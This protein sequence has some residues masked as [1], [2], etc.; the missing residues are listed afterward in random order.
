MIRHHATDIAD[1]GPTLAEFGYGDIII[2]VITPANGCLGAYGVALS[3]ANAPRP[4]GTDT[5]EHNG[6]TT[7]ELAPKMLMTFTQV[8]SF[9]SLISRLMLA[10][11]LFLKAHPKVRKANV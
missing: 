9:D 5:P 11:K 2:S 4:P 10:K 7:K 8:A 3:N 1:N 6:K